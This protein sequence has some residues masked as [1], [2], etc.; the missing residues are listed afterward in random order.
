MTAELAAPSRSLQP[1]PLL[2]AYALAW[3]GG[4][5]AY[6]P[7]LTVLLPQRLTVLAGDGDVRW[8]GIAATVGA[9]AASV[10]N[11]GWGWLSDRIGRRLWPAA[12]GLVAFACATALVARSGSAAHLVAALAVWQVALN[13]ILAPLAAWA[14]D[15]IPNAQKGLLGGL[16]AVGPGIAAASLLGIALLPDDLGIQLALIVAITVAAAAPLLVMRKPRMNPQVALAPTAADHNS[17]TLLQLWFARLTVQVAEGLLFL[18][19]YYALRRLSGG[20]LSLTHYALS[21]AAAQICAIPVAITIG[22]WSDRTGR[23]RGPLLSM[24]A[25]IALGLAIMAGS[26]SWVP[27]VIGYSVFLIG[28]NSFL[29]LHSTFAMQ[30]LR[31]PRHHGRDLGLFNLTN[32]IPALIAPLLAVTIIGA[33][34][35]SGLLAGLALAMVIPAALVARLDLR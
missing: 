32:T 28:S 16:L 18:F 3:A 12:V 1:L 8:L 9:L 33:I 21:A 29:S 24:I 17:R 34:G 30:Q 27:A 11:I 5:I 14:A 25:M 20:Q 26:R 4:C 2:A 13:L 10:S 23:R 22:R 31:N 19:L 7:F 15:H 35:Y 6:T